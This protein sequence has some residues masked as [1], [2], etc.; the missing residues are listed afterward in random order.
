VDDDAALAHAMLAT[1]DNPLPRWQL[2]E[3]ARPYAIEAST[4]AYLDAMELPPCLV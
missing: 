1:L 2:Q 3:A 4:D